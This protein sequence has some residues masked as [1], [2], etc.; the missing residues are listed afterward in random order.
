MAK[1]LILGGGVE[2]KK[3]GRF[4]FVCYLLATNHSYSA[5]CLFQRCTGGYEWLVQRSSERWPAGKARSVYGSSECDSSELYQFVSGRKHWL[6]IFLRMQVLHFAVYFFTGLVG[7]FL[8]CL[9][10]V[11]LVTGYLTY[12]LTDKPHLIY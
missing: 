7:N 9:T 11:V 12:I 6:E 5:S 2:R 3:R 1:P 4:S 10:Y 8:N